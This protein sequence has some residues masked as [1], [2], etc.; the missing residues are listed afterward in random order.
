M[1]QKSLVMVMDLEIIQGCI[2]PPKIIFFTTPPPSIII[3]FIQFT[4]FSRD[5]AVH[6]IW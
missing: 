6:N 1:G 4:T 2:K 3:F 5:K